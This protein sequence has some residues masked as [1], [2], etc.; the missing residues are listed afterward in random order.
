M[1][2]QKASTKTGSGSSLS[3]S[4]LSLWLG[5]L[6]SERY[7]SMLVALKSQ[8]T[9]MLR[10]HATLN[11]YFWSSNQSGSSGRPTEAF[12]MH[13]LP[14]L[15]DLVY[16]VP[17]LEWFDGGASSIALFLARKGL[18]CRMA[19]AFS[20]SF[21][22]PPE[23]L[24]QIRQAIHHPQ[25]SPLSSCFPSTDARKDLASTQLFDSIQMDATATR[26]MTPSSLPLGKTWIVHHER[27]GPDSL[28][29]VMIRNPSASLPPQAI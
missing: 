20:C 19:R 8:H 29:S 23:S 13:R 5:S 4:G 12:K 18:L 6:V 3:S 11:S 28:S 17:S 26:R 7:V 22:D 1:K 24:S 16:I 21:G 10:V 14:F 15:N 27:S 25:F 9:Y 2:Y